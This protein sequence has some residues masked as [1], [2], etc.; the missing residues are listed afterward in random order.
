MKNLIY[1]FYLII[2][3]SNISYAQW[4]L[5]YMSSGR[6]Q[7]QSARMVDTIY[8]IAGSGA[9]ISSAVDAYNTVS[10]SWM[11]VSNISSPRCF[12][13]SVGGDSALYVA[14]GLTSFGDPLVG[15]N[16]IDIYKNGIWSTDTLPDS[17]WAATAVHVGSK[18]LIAGAYTS[19]SFS[20][21][22][23][24]VSNL[25]YVFDELTNSWTVDTLSEARGNPAVASDGVIAIFAGGHSGKNLPSDAVDIYNSVTDTWTAAT[26]SE[27][28][29]HVGGVYAGGKF[30]FAGGIKSGVGNSSD[31]IDIYDG[32]NWTVD[33]LSFPRGG[34]Y[35]ASA[36]G[37]IFFP[38]GG[39][40][41]LLQL[42]FISSESLVDVYDIA[43]ASWSTNH[44]NFDKINHTSLGYENR[45]YVAGGAQVPGTLLDAVEIWDVATGVHFLNPFDKITAYPNPAGDLVTLKGIENLSGFIDGVI[46]TCDGSVVSKVTGIDGGIDISHLSVGLYFLNIRYDTGTVTVKLIKE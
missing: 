9:A 3:L 19:F 46:T 45:I 29:A 34:I 1:T 28:R 25:V 18:I 14:G 43:S 21:N 23:P 6:A 27:A 36:G 44:M 5:D 31:V 15:T 10:G 33:Y 26:L 13:A 16:V 11:P 4:S 7:L 30:Y 22:T 40:M 32:T 35:P 2:C 37:K 38:G 41:D 20:T 12:T 17:I 39:D 42:Y 24:I 8:F